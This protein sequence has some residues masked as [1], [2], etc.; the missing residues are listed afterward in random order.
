MSNLDKP[1]DAV[2]HVRIPT[3]DGW[4]AIAILGVMCCHI[5]WP[6]PYSIGRVFIL[7]GWGVQLFFALSG[8]LITS[9]L[10]DEYDQT[11]KIRWGDFY[12]RRVFR[13]LPPAFFL[14]S[15]LAVLGLGLRLI[16]LDGKSILAV[17]LFYRNYVYAGGWYTAHFWSLAVEEHFYLMWP[18]ILCIVGAAR[19]G[20]TAVTLVFMAIVWH[21]ADSYFNWIGH[22]WP[23]LHGDIHR[24]DYNLDV[25]FLGAALAYLWRWEPARVALQRVVRSYWVLG[26]WAAQLLLMSTR[27]SSWQYT[28]VELLMA[29]LPLITIADPGSWLSRILETRWLAWIGR[30]SYSLYLWQQLTLRLTFLP[31]VFQQLPVNVLLTF[32]AASFSYYFVERRFIQ[33]GGRIVRRRSVKRRL[34]PETTAAGTGVRG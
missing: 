24:T 5:Q 13:I 32:L 17:I 2:K 6:L 29:P 15:V 10:L 1:S 25:L 22:F 14:L 12:I 21:I 28:G 34:L 4:R 11:G 9:R 23:L 3:L 16:P 27:S 18:A 19:G 20:R 31:R 26:I 33:L 7:G 8:F 30:L